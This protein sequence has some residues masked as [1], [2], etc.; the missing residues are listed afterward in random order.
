MDKEVKNILMNHE[1]RISVLEAG[2]KEIHDKIGDM[3]KKLDRIDESLN[4]MKGKMN[5]IGSSTNSSN[6]SMDKK[7]FIAIIA[8]QATS[9]FLLITLILKLMMT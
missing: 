7:Q 9:I 4:Y 2:F 1:K 5:S 6:N 8:T 3:G